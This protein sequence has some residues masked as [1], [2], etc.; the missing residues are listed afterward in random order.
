MIYITLRYF[1]SRLKNYLFCCVYAA[2]FDTSFFTGKFT[3][4]VKFSTT[5]FTVSNYL[6]ISNL[7]WVDWEGLFYA[8]AERKSSYFVLGIDG[9]L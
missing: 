8:Y 3:Q 1:L 9:R 6:D 5:Y 2:L 7:W 4:I